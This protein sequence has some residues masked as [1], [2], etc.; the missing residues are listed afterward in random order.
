[1]P[2]KKWKL[3]FFEDLS[4]LYKKSIENKDYP[5]IGL[6]QIEKYKNPVFSINFEDSE[7]KLKILTVN[8]M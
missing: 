7:A 8:L 1:M 5:K 4:S 6:E 3:K 2:E